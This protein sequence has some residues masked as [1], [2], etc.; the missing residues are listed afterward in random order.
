MSVSVVTWYLYQ[1]RHDKKVIIFFNK[2]FFRYSGSGA[3]CNNVLE[4]I[5]FFRCMC[6]IFTP[7]ATCEEIIF[8]ILF[9]DQSQTNLWIAHYFIFAGTRKTTRRRSHSEQ[10]PGPAASH[11]CRKA[12]PGPAASH[13]CRKATPRPAAS[14]LCKAIPRTSSVSSLQGHPPDQQRLIFARPSPGPA[15]S[16]LCMVT[17]RTS[18]ISSLQGHP[19][20]QQRLIFAGPSPGPAATHLCR[21]ATR[22]FWKK[23]NKLINLT[24]TN[25]VCCLCYAGYRSLPH[26]E[27]GCQLQKLAARHN[28]SVRQFL[29]V[30]W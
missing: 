15:A 20:D 22:L 29:F 21:K 13:L 8:L 14:H 4:V 5:Y 6:N 7:F 27:S 1:W 24:I 17:P 30:T 28:Y 10:S 2:L 26:S 18:S 3:A 11:L 19:P 12:T 16:H 9:T 23:T 25:V